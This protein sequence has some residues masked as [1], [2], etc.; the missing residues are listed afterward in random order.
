M[1]VTPLDRSVI[2]FLCMCLT[3]VLPSGVLYANDSY[4]QLAPPGEGDWFS[5]QNWTLGIPRSGDYAYVTNGGTAVISSGVAYV[6]GVN[7]GTNTDPK[8][9]E[10]KQ[11]G[12]TLSTVYDLEIGCGPE[13]S[14]TYLLQEGRVQGMNVRVGYFG[15]GSFVQS[16]GVN[17]ANEVQVPYAGGG[18]GRYELGGGTLEVGRIR[19]GG[20]GTGVLTQTAGM[21]RASSVYVG[22]DGGADATYEVSGGVVDV[23]NLYTGRASPVRPG[24]FRVVGSGAQIDVD[25]YWLYGAGHL[26]SQ[27]DASGLSLIQVSGSASLSGT[28]EV[29]DDD[30][31][32]GHW[33]VLSV[34]GTL[35]G[36][37]SLVTL[38]GADWRWGIAGNSLWVEH[39]PEPVTLALLAL[40]GLPLIRRHRH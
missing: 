8:T 25:Q 28:W 17:A 4:W 39:V 10:V 40:G 31:P 30:A 1:P 33:N 22:W 21:N 19:V 16:G 35:N 32:V 37:P 26:V 11:V 6:R 23:I 3:A 27:V 24:T 14:G 9:G 7:I 20:P 12:G 15:E 18:C 38:P 36:T 13:S 5:P 29:V 34:A 2:V